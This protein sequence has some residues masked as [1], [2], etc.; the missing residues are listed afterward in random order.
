MAALHRGF[1][2]VDRPVLE[3]VLDKTGNDAR[4]AIRTLL[5]MGFKPASAH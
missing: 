3:K 2:T 4:A 1:P 5:Q